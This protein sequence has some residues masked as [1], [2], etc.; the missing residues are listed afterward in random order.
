MCLSHF[1]IVSHKLMR[2]ST[3]NHTFVLFQRVVKTQ[4]K[5]H[6]DKRHSLKTKN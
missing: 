5:K 3:N 1:G 4:S 2:I 6:N